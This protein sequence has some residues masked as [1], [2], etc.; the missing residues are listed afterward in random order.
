M[1]RVLPETEG[2]PV[3]TWPETSAPD[4]DIASSSWGFEASRAASSADEG[5][6]PGQKSSDSSG[7]GR[8]FRR[9][10]PSRPGGEG[11]GVDLRNTWQVVAGSILVPLGVVLILI[12]WYGAAH[13]AYVQQQIPY[14]VSGSFAGLGCMVLGGLFYWAHWLY[15]LYDQADQH[16]E[17]QLQ[18]MQMTLRAIAERLPGGNGWSS[19]HLAGPE[20]ATIQGRVQPQPPSHAPAQGHSGAGAAHDVS[21]SA[22]PVSATYVVTSAGTVYHLPSCPIIAHHTEGLRVLGSGAVVGMEQCRICMPGQGV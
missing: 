21:S 10:L 18:A 3:E 17:E 8:F 19:P 11:N 16:H 20:G 22:G 14:L 7:G 13:T 6:P 2:Q 15:R 5:A 1:V 4:R 12:A 9:L